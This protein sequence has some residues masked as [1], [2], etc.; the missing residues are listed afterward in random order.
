MTDSGAAEGSDVR[1]VDDNMEAVELA[2]RALDERAADGRA[3]FD[4]AK[5]LGY[6]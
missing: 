6:F 1:G 3:P 4:A 5:R 2:G